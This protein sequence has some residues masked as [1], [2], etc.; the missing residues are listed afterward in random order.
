MSVGSRPLALLLWQTTS[1]SSQAKFSL[2]IFIRSS[3]GP[4]SEA[5][6]G[7]QSGFGGAIDSRSLSLVKNTHL[8][9]ACIHF[10][11][12]ISFERCFQHTICRKHKG[13]SEEQ[14][15]TGG[16]RLQ[17]SCLTSQL[18]EAAVQ[19]MEICPQE[20]NR[21]LKLLALPCGSS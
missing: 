19:P 18:R 1:P 12:S 11:T 7:F 9:T 6:R 4:W 3:G 15:G 2:Y 16:W 21:L 13:A 14:T 5:S 10:F 20:S 17:V 8:A